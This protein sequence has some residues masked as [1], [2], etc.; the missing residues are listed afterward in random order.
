MKKVIACLIAALLFASAG[1]TASLADD[2]TVPRIIDAPNGIHVAG[3]A[4]YTL[5][6]GGLVQQLCHLDS[7]PPGDLV[8]VTIFLRAFRGAGSG[9][10]G[11]SEAS[12]ATNN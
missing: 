3:C 5:V 9:T 6:D 7:I 8:S 1:A 11:G 10:D 2:A 4:D 12:S